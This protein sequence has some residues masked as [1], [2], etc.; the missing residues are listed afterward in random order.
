[1]SRGEDRLEVEIAAPL[2]HVYQ[3]LIN[4]DERKN[5]MLGVERVDRDP[6]T[7][8]IGM[9]HNC[10][11]QGLVMENTALSSEFE[12]ERARYV[13]Q[14]VIADLGIDALDVYSLSTKDGGTLLDFNLD[15]RDSPLPREAKTQMLGG[16]RANLEAFK[17]LCEER[18]LEIPAHD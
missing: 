15:W 2:R 7:E 10:V 13:E 4:V 8:R 14:A 18:S 17:R 16:I 6:V 9:R 12:D 1:M 3:L 11:F 5:W